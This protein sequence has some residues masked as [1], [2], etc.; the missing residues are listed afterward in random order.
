MAPPCTQAKRHLGH[1]GLYL[2][3]DL[4]DAPA[5]AAE[6]QDVCAEV[7]ASGSG[8]FRTR[9]GSYDD[10]VLAVVIAVW[11]ARSGA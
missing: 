10:F 9:Y 1:R 6:L 5:P 8:R 11:R 2:Q 3:R 4:L 7:T